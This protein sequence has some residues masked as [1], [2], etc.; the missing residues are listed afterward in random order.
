V[1]RIPT[2]CA[3][4]FHH[5]DAGSF[6]SD[7]VINLFRA[8]RSFRILLALKGLVKTSTSPVRASTMPT[9]I[10]TNG[11]SKL[12]G[13]SKEKAVFPFG[14]LRFQPSAHGL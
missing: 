13:L 12:K 5:Y 6:F 10:K 2:F 9:V 3:K 4:P 11:K 7:L 8:F 14:W 1:S